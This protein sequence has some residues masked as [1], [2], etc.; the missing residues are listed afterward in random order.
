[1]GPGEKKYLEKNG[2]PAGFML[3][4][5]IIIFLIWNKIQI[6]NG[7]EIEPKNILIKKINLLIKHVKKAANDQKI[8]KFSPQ[9]LLEIKWIT[10]D[11]NDELIKLIIIQLLKNGFRHP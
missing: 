6:L 10:E 4:N 8:L 9:E 5:E 7:D 3:I 11:K 2:P 1:M